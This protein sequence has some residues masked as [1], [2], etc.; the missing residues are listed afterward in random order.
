M[1]LSFGVCTVNNPSSSNLQL[2]SLRETIDK[3]DS[4]LISLLLERFN[5]SKKI[6]IVKEE[7]QIQVLDHRREEDVK[8]HWIQQSSNEV[9]LL[10]I[11]ESILQV[12]KAIQRNLNS[13]QVIGE[14]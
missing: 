5:Q 9:D 7:L 14:T 6:G 8:K 11:L 13:P 12:S 1:I 2:Q 4:Q 10:P 3:I